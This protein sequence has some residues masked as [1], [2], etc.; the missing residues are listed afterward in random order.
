VP[1]SYIGDVSVCHADGIK[2]G[3]LLGNPLLAQVTTL[4]DVPDED[5]TAGA[6]DPAKVKARYPTHPLVTSGAIK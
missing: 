2:S 6:L 1:G 5:C 4:V 3:I